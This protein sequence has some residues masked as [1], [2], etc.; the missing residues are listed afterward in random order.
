M[1]SPPFQGMEKGT[2]P[3]MEMELNSI[4]KRTHPQMTQMNADKDKGEEG[5]ES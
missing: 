4:K 1:G 2:H 5:Q 3:Q